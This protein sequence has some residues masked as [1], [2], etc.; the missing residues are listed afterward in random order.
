MTCSPGRKLKQTINGPWSLQYSSKIPTTALPPSLCSIALSHV[1]RGGLQFQYPGPYTEATYFSHPFTPVQLR[2]PPVNK[3]VNAIFISQTCER[4]IVHRI[5]V[6]STV[7]TNSC[8]CYKLD[9]KAMRGSYTAYL[10]M[11]S[12][13]WLFQGS[14]DRQVLL[15][16]REDKRPVI[17]SSGKEQ[18]SP[19]WPPVEVVT[20]HQMRQQ[21]LVK[22]EGKIH[23]EVHTP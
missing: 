5:E 6:D 16:S 21:G 14:R 23:T 7:R 15:L 18:L 19:V 9:P 10:H 3:V 11:S 4:N 13:A 8:C 17:M 20:Q 2:S 22:T 1:G 12:V